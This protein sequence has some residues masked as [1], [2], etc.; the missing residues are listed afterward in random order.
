VRTKV[1]YPKGTEQKRYEG[2]LTLSPFQGHRLVASYINVE[3]D[4]LG[5]S[6][7]SILDTRSL[8][9]RQ[10]PQDLTAFNYTGVITENFFVEAQYSERHYTFENSGSKFT[11]RINGTLMI[12]NLTTERWWSPTFCG[13]CRPEKRDNE[14]ILAKGSWF[15]SSETLGSHDLAFGYDT[16]EDIRIADNFQ[17]GSGFR[18][19]TTKAI[20]RGTELFPQLISGNTNT[21][22]QY[23]PIL[24]SSLGT[25]FKTNSLF[26]NDR[27][28][29]N[30]RWSFNLGLRYD[31][32]DGKDSAGTKVADDSRIS[33][34]FGAAWD[35]RGDGDWVLNASYGQYVAAIASTQANGASQGGNSAEYRWHYRGPSIN[36]DDKA[37]NLIPTDVALQ[38]IFAWFDSQ[39]G[40][41]NTSNIRSIIIPGGTTQI[42]GNSLSSPYQDEWAVGA[43]KRLGS[44]GLFRADVVHRE[45]HDYY[46][47]RTDTTTG[48]VKTPNGTDADLTLIENDNSILE[49]EYNGLHTQFQYRPMDSLSLG[50]V[51]TWSEATGNYDGETAANGPVSAADAQYPEFKQA[52][53]NNPS[54][55]LA[56]DQPHRVRVWAIYDIFSS[57]HHSLNVGILQN[58]ASGLPYGAVGRVNSGLSVTNPGYALPPPNVNYYFTARDEFRTDDITATDL[59]LNYAFTWRTLGKDVEIFLQPEVLNV[60]NEAGVVNVN[61][62]VN[63]ATRVARCPASDPFCTNPNTKPNPAGFDHF[64]PFTGK[65]VEGVHWAKAAT[66][67]KPQSKDDYQQP[68]TFR[69]S[70][71]FRF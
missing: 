66:F 67:G 38:Q 69:L 47:S 29:L 12:D 18:V 28:R 35:L 22:I 26:L 1:S 33:P 11:D 15:L 32:N 46:L 20:D 70:V 25:S 48:R 24:V 40:I 71:G 34:R 17:S 16:F 59:T 10:L 2:K 9:D 60:F 6:F 43:S 64:N 21:F 52:R 4:D 63:D 31:Q 36:A 57:D 68:R 3:E 49:R 7:G 41:N 56:N 30:D 55:A 19:F 54:G 13:V 27:W 51:W 53:W 14:N 39:G 37:P 61:T 65:P 44:K 45:G 8:N 62:S 23:N 58:Y 42:R 50:G 5:N